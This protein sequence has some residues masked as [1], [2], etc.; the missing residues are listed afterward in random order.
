MTRLFSTDGRLWGTH[1]LL[2]AMLFA[3]CVRAM[4]NEYYEVGKNDAVYLA[5]TQDSGGHL[6]GQVEIATMVSNGST[7]L[8]TTNAAFSGTRSGSDVSLTFG[9]LSAFG[10]ATWT[11]HVGW[12]T[13]SLVIPTGDVPQRGSLSAGSFDDFQ[14]AVRKMQDRV[15]MNQAHLALFNASTEAAGHLSKGANLINRGLK[16]LEE[17]FP[18]QPAS[19]S[20]KARYARQWEA[21][22][23]A[24]QKEQDAAAVVPMTCYQKSQ[25]S[26]QSAQVS[27]QLAQFDYLDAQVSYAHDHFDNAKQDV[28]DGIAELGRWA[29]IFNSRARAYATAV[30]KKFSYNAVAAL[31]PTISRARESLAYYA[32]RWS[33]LTA[34]VSDFDQRAKEQNADAQAFPQT[35]SCTE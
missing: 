35:I 6:Q 14:S 9:L 3:S 16:Q 29:P 7:K 19:D 31:A 5:W 21:M 32:E 20:L 22:Q 23:A 27:Y 10:S 34:Y 11:G 15:A 1:I 28:L 13:L 12:N 18:K 8:R 33:S 2:V 25:V 17:L 26:F 4:A 30:G 24:W